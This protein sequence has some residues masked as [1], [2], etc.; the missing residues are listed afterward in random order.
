M[1]TQ[2]AACMLLLSSEGPAEVGLD[3][4]TIETAAAQNKGHSQVSGRETRSPIEDLMH[5]LDGLKIEYRSDIQFNAI[6]NGK[7][8]SRKLAEEI[9]QNLFNDA[10]L[11][12]YPYPFG[13]TSTDVDTRDLAVANAL[14]AFHLDALSIRLRGVQVLKSWNSAKSLEKFQ[15]IRLAVSPVEC[16]STLVPELSTYYALLFSLASSGIS[17]G[18]KTREDVFFWIHAQVQGMSSP[19]QLAP[20]ATMLTKLDIGANEFKVLADA[21]SARLAQLQA[22]DRESAYIQ[23]KQS[24]AAEI[25]TLAS[26]LR[27]DSWPVDPL[28]QSYK[29]F[30]ERSAEQPR[31]SDATTDWKEVLKSFNDL[32]DEYKVKDVGKL[33]P[34]NF[35]PS[36]ES[37]GSADVHVPP[38]M[39]AVYAALGK[40]MALRPNH[41]GSQNTDGVQDSSGWESDVDDALKKLDGIDPSRFDCYACAASAKTSVLFA[42][43]DSV[44][45]KRWKQRILKYLIRNL[46]DQTMERDAPVEWLFSVDILLNTARKPSAQ[47]EQELDRLVKEGKAP[48]A[49]PSIL[50]VEILKAMEQSGD[51]T[52]YSYANADEILQNGYIIPPHQD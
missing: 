28:F 24:I 42:Y 9:V 39:T 34:S 4:H 18:A 32:I 6:E 29:T 33:D 45:D 1:L 7:I 41:G 50:G 27:G 15:S 21:Y 35:K 14:S 2:L 51:N 40:V 20:M 38:D 10:E 46:A 12:T 8:T 22:T 31:C 11:A 5:S 36:S 47:Q 37:G 23:K 48:N 16:K 44:P 19:L 52:L 17:S 30:I 13:L 3:A 43:F 49:L 26:T 25:R